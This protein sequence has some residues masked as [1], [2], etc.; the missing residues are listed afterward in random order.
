MLGF[1][2]FSSEFG[3]SSAFTFWMVVLSIILTLGFTVVV[4][5]G[6][7]A[8]LRF[9]LRAM[10]GQQTESVDEGLG[11]RPPP[12]ELVAQAQHDDAADAETSKVHS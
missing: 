3:L 1:I 4:F 5:F 6:G 2:T 12:E 11:V 10:D 8:D 9:L 7:L